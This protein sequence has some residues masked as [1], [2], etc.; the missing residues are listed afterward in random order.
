[1]VAVLVWALTRIALASAYLSDHGV[2][3]RIFAIIEVVSS[4]VLAISTA[5]LVQALIQ[6]ASLRI[7]GHGF[8]ALVAFGAPDAY[9][10]ASGRGLSWP[11]YAVIG[12]LI[13]TS[14]GV[15][16]LQL[17]RSLAAAREPATPEPFDNL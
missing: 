17:R 10:L 2:D 3:I 5:R 14:S 4:P 13:V 12:T 6:R 8:V 7:L 16:A 1:M 11:I 15:S 9:L